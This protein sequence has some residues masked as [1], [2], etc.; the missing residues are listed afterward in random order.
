MCG[1]REKEGA[2]GIPYTI[3]MPITPGR[4]W[5]KRVFGIKIHAKH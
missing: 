1:K 4:R 3:N 5:V 2:N